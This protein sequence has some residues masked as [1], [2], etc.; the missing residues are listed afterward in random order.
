MNKS[1][2]DKKKKTIIQYCWVC[3]EKLDITK[4]YVEKY[5]EDT[6]EPIKVRVYKCPNKRFFQLASHDKREFYM[7]GE[8]KIDFGG[9]PL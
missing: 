2:K 9:Y 4:V 1:R 7:D 8:E 3:G 6:G 5:D